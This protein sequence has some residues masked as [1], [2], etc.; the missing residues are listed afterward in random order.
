MA[1][2][3]MSVVGTKLQKENAEMKKLLETFVLW[4]SLNP[5][6]RGLYQNEFDAALADAKKLVQ[7]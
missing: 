4:H 6:N 7:K 3:V 5:E 1:K 2:S